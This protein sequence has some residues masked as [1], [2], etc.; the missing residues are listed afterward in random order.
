MTAM[1]T[2]QTMTPYPILFLIALLSAWTCAP[3]SAGEDSALNPPPIEITTRQLPSGYPGDEY[4]THL[5]TIGGQGPVSFLS[6]NLLPRGLSLTRSGRL[7]GTL[8]AKPGNHSLFVIAVDPSQPDLFDETRLTLTIHQ[9]L[10]L[11]VRALAPAMDRAPYAYQIPVQGGSP[12]I[13]ARITGLPAGLSMDPTGLVTGIPEQGP[14]RYKL[15]LTV[16]DPDFPTHRLSEKLSLRVYAPL[17]ILTDS[18]APLCVGDLLTTTLTAQGGSGKRMFT[19]EDLPLGL[20]LN[21]ASGQISGLAQAPRGTYDV[22][23]SVHDQV[24]PVLVSKT[25]TLTLVDFYPDAY[26]PMETNEKRGPNMFKPGDPV[27]EH[28]FD[29]PGDLDTVFLDLNALNR[30]DV[31]QI[32]T[33]ARTKKTRPRLSLRDPSGHP[34]HSAVSH[35]EAGYPGLL[36]VCDAPGTYRLDIDDAR[37]ETG[38]YNLALERLGPR[39]ALT[40]LALP[41]QQTPGPVDLMVNAADGSGFHV[42][43]ADGLPPDLCISPEGRIHGQLNAAA[44]IYPV[45]IHVQDRLWGNLSDQRDYQLTLMDFFPDAFEALEG[46]RLCDTRA[47]LVP[48]SPMQRHTFHKPGDIDAVRLDLGHQHTDRVI[49]IRTLP[50]TRNTPTYL[51]VN[52]HEGQ[53]LFTDKDRPGPSCA[54]LS[55]THQKPLFLS[56]EQTDGRT[57]EYSLGVDDLGPRLRIETPAL[58]DALTRGPYAVQ[59]TATQGSGT[60]RF[61]GQNLPFGLTL[62]QTGHLSGHLAMAPGRY[63]LTIRAQDSLYTGI[64]DTRH[65]SL[66][67][68]TFFPDAFEAMN[69]ED[70][71]TINTM[72]PGDAKQEH[73]FH[74]A[75]DTDWVRLDLSRVRPK[76]VIIIEAPVQ[77]KQTRTELRLFDNPGH[78]PLVS[79]TGESAVGT[80]M[81][82]SCERPGIYWLEI[83]EP[84]R[85]IGAYHLTLSNSG[86]PVNILTR[87]LNPAES[88]DPYTQKLDTQG[89]SGQ[90]R[91]SLIRGALPPGLRLD[92]DKG[93]LGGQNTTWGHFTFSIL[94]EDRR[95]PQNRSE[96]AYTMDA[97]MGKKLH[98]ESRFVF[99]HYLS[100]TFSLDTE[101]ETT[102]AF[103]GDITG[104]T[105][106]N[107][108]Y[109]I[110]DHTLPGERFTLTFD[111][112]TGVFDLNEPSPLSCNQ[113]VDVDLDVTVEVKDSVHTNNSFIF[114]YEIPARCLSY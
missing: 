27:Q 30:G 41:D 106:G 68:V 93:L 91:F 59:L 63:D 32:L 10:D 104:G 44:G 2:Q 87:S 56:I 70:P 53:T 67:V 58:P 92:P 102:R 47:T 113:Y 26:E 100:G 46:D 90:H 81:V 43:S 37:G 9:P 96:Q 22:I 18:P 51:T 45:T 101:T 33:R 38:D 12:G 52:D 85:G 6:P 13:Q 76:D 107:L 97:Y 89:G 105:P 114:H 14:A 49:R 94:A 25:L 110:V 23:V 60:Y 83:R 74:D 31:V 57:G 86:Q 40:T 64:D 99:P 112:Q 72:S 3:V 16:M 48:G 77:D 88:V 35:D 61:S 1:E 24:L 19:A 75:G 62:D 78:S 34:V 7:Y 66:N 8:N 28:T 54:Y 11:P 69:D 111:S 65:F 50:L 109:R 80:P 15:M 108:R 82:F 20:S 36:L 103:P 5:E 39:L 95:F 79:Q 17:R 73:C 98:G 4:S 29:Q 21:A 71:G 84:A 55:I 42:F